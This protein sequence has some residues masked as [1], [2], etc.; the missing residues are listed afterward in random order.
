MNTPLPFPARP[1]TSPDDSQYIGRRYVLDGYVW[2]I[3]GVS[4]ETETHL[5][6]T[7][8]LAHCPPGTRSMPVHYQV[9]AKTELVD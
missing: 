2:Q 7:A 9:L 6:V 1:D 8:V 4:T 5:W 3:V